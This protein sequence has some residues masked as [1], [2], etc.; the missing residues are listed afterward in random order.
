LSAACSARNSAN[1]LLATI[2]DS[3]MIGAPT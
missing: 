3:R 1:T 2:I